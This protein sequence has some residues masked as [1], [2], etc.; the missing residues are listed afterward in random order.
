MEREDLEKK[1]EI[2]EEILENLHKIK[3]ALKTGSGPL[4]GMAFTD[5]FVEN[6]NAQIR[7]AKEP[8]KRYGKN[9][10]SDS[11][12]DVVISNREFLQLRKLPEYDIM[13]KGAHMR[14]FMNAKS[15]ILELVPVY[16]DL[17]MRTE[18]IRDELL[19]LTGK[20]DKS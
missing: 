17:T 7:Q 11:K 18:S 15:N 3:K 12:G 2:T 6:I 8:F 1:L 4:S 5:N 13:T 10:I 9:D 16:E 19:I 14:R 20:N